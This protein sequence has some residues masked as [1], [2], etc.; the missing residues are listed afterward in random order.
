MASSD[1]MVCE[2]TTRASNDADALTLEKAKWEFE[3]SE[4]S[5]SDKRT[6][7]RQI[8]VIK[9]QARFRAYIRKCKKDEVRPDLSKWAKATFNA[10][11]FIGAMVDPERKQK[12]AIAALKGL[13]PEQM[14]AV[15]KTIQA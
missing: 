10:K 9:A 5:E 8:L 6:L 13:T 2:V 1:K 3:L 14:A 11:D 4:L 7:L 12:K 15:L